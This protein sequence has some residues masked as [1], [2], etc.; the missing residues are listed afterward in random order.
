MKMDIRWKG[1]SVVDD[2]AEYQNMVSG[3]KV[4]KRLQMRRPLQL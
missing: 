3:M 4:L 1:Q 2:E